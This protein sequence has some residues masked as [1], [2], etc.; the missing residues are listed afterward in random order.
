MAV[1]AVAIGLLESAMYVDAL[2]V[3]VLGMEMGN[4]FTHGVS[5]RRREAAQSSVERRGLL[6]F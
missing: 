1:K 6:F 5:E 4:G 2:A 3:Y